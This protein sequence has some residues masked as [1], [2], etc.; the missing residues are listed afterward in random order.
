MLAKGLIGDMSPPCVNGIARQGNT[1]NQE[2]SVQGILVSSFSKGFTT[3]NSGTDTFTVQLR[4]APKE[5][6]TIPLVASVSGQVT[7]SPS[8]LSFSPSNWN[9]PQ[10]V[11]VTGLDDL[12][13]L[14][15][16]VSLVINLGP[17]QSQ[18]SGSASLLAST[19]TFANRDFRRIIF[20]TTTN[21][22]QGGALGGVT[23]A[24]SLCNSDSGK[25]A[26]T[27][28]YQA[29]IATGS[30]RRASV[31][32][33]LGDGQIDWVFLPNQLYVRPSGLTVLTT[34]ANSIFIFGTL[35][36]SIGTTGDLTW[37]GL[38]ADWTTAGGCGADWNNT[39]VFGR[40]GVDN[41]TGLT[42]L[43]GGNIICSS[44]G[45]LVCVQQ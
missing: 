13:A 19:Q 17:S 24:D 2:D 36:N 41:G 32:A 7:I 18:D 39:S 44:Q 9:I 29:M 21:T 40:Y 23:G 37:T 26:N 30:I 1:N 43:N 34:N 8:S 16:F 38:N 45:R 4:R 42:V 31:T 11:T 10:T 3:K 25:P 35:T 22:L 28:I 27:G 15:T 33:N 14:G 12:A 20:S 6:V 5:T